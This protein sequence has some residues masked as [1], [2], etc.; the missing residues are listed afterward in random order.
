[1]LPERSDVVVV[2]G[3]VVGAA[4]LSYLV[5]LGCER[6]VLLERDTL[7]SGSTGRCAGGVRTIFSDDLNVRLGAEAIRR[8]E[9]FED[10]IGERLDLRLWGYL[11]CLDDAADAAAF[12]A[13]LPLQERE[14]VP[15]R[16]L[17]PEEAL[18]IV[19]QLAVDD[20]V[21]AVFCPTAGY[22]TP[23]LV[24]QGYA[25][26]AAAGGAHVEQS[27][28][29]SAILVERG[30]VVGVETPRGRIA[31]DRVV[32]AA[33]VWSR[34]LAATAGLDLPVT[35]ERRWMFFTEDA[36][37]F[38][39][40]LPLTIDFG[41]SFYFHREGGGLALGGREQT[42]EELAPQGVRR[43]P[44]LAD[45]G[46]RS[47]WSGLYEMSPD[48]NALVGAAAEPEGLSYA[49]GFSG[50]GFQQA[51]VVGEHLARLALGLEPA[52]DL[53]ALGVERFAA[54]LPRVELNVV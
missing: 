19:P 28:A 54:G 1:M 25:R 21:A 36:P 49:T 27:C 24:V 10:E 23:D 4:A 51:P 45:L 11:F 2:G 43:L 30:R 20:L 46:I 31:T 52:F 40:E 33:G 48:H 18:E 6:P 44:A 13:A 14:G 38:P 39:H 35:P 29:A 15:S 42:I 9:R 12:A 17:R 16:L 34:E 7:G 50:H 41:T 32:C 47:S 8:L 5:D 3:G 22:V 37:G 26:H 53:S